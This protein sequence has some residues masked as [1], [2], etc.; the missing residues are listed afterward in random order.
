MPEK[1]YIEF[2]QS[3][4]LPQDLP[5]NLPMKSAN[6]LGPAEVEFQKFPDEVV[7]T[8]RPTGNWEERI[9]IDDLELL[10]DVINGDASAKEYLG[11]IKSIFSTL[12]KFAVE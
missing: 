11:E 9:T 12:E 3:K 8:I 1:G 10:R 4:V 2:M 5:T 6:V 7:V